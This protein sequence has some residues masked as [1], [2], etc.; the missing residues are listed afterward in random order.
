[1]MAVLVADLGGTNA[2]LALAGDAVRPDSVARYRGDD[3]PRFDD[4]IADYLAAQGHPHIE[5]VCMAVAG[6][7]RGGA[8]RLTNRDWQ[9]S[10]EGLMAQTGAK[11]ALLINDMIA[12]GHAVRPLTQAPRATVREAPGGDWN[13]QALV[14]NA[15]TGFNICPVL[16][17]R[18]GALCLEAEEG[19]T[20]LP[21]TIHAQLTGLLGEGA[22][23]FSSTEAL[24]AGPGLARLHKALTGR[25]E[26]PEAIAD[27]GS[28]TVALMARLFGELLRE[29]AV[30]FMPGAGIWLAGSNARTLG[31]Y[32]AQIAQGFGRSDQMRDI[33]EATGIYLMEDDHAALSGCLA[34]L[35]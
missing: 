13:R 12:L 33:P 11:K 15:G 16:L 1:M 27:A 21:A 28:E 19:H 3:Y 34:A 4:V 30:R 17:G 8:A 26:T 35:T 9:L 5:A 18:D 14:V 24:F 6:P 22:K 31:R 10:T 7:V 25:D 32:G 20:A 23:A 2:R 29:M